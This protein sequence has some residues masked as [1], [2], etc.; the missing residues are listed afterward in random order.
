MKNGKENS[1]KMTYYNQSCTIKKP[2]NPTVM[3]RVSWVPIKVDCNLRN[4]NKNHVVILSIVR[5]DVL[6]ID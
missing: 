1:N 4:K 3:K 2:D 6:K 5:I